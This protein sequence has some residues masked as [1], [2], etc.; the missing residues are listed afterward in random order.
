MAIFFYKRDRVDYG[1]LSNFY[2]ST[3]CMG[4]LVYL[5]NEHWYQSQKPKRQEQRQEIAT[6]PTA[7]EAKKLGG[8]CDLRGDWEDVKERIMLIGLHAKFVQNPKLY[9]KL[10]E[11]G[12]EKLVEDSPYDAYWGAPKGKGKNRLGVLLMDLRSH[13]KCHELL[14]GILVWDGM[15]LCTPTLAGRGA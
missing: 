7:R 4:G 10:L 12:E 3:F 6:A 14:T 11:T 8:D 9:L 13:F 2:R 15:V 5:T 1:F